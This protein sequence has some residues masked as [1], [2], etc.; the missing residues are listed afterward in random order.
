MKTFFRLMD[1]RR[2]YLPVLQSSI[3]PMLKEV[4]DKYAPLY[5]LKMQSRVEGIDVGLEQAAIE[6]KRAY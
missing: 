4:I 5:E 3:D 1:K 2:P 6:H